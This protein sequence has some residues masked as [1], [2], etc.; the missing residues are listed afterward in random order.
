[1][2]TYTMLMFK[3]SKYS[4]AKLETRVLRKLCLFMAFLPLPTC[5]AT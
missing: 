3:A 1:M 2:A 5:I 4:T